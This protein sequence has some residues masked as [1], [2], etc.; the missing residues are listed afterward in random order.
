MTFQGLSPFCCFF[1]AAWISEQGK[2]L[3][4][5]GHSSHSGI[6]RQHS[7]VKGVNLDDMFNGLFQIDPLTKW[8]T[9]AKQ[10]T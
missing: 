2:P 4:N 8:V 5:Y 9:S 3:S 10:V 7:R 6:S 1:H